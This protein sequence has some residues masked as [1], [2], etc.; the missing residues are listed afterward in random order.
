[1]AQMALVGILMLVL[2]RFVRLGKVIQ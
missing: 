1:V 2:D